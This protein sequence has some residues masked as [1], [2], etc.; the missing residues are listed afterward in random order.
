[1]TP[2]RGTRKGRARPVRSRSVAQ[3]TKTPSDRRRRCRPSFTVRRFWR[4]LIDRG[5]HSSPRVG[6]PT[7]TEREH[8]HALAG[9]IARRSRRKVLLPVLQSSVLSDPLVFIRRERALFERR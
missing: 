2:G 7:K 4:Q 1:M 8:A 5:P 9:R 3:S 6:E